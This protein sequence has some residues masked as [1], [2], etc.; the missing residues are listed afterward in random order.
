MGS[1]QA[2]E[3]PQLSLCPL[4]PLQR[5]ETVLILS[6]GSAC[7]CCCHVSGELSV[8][9]HVLIL[10]LI[11]EILLHTLNVHFKKVHTQN[12]LIGIF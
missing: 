4:D 6:L 7:L 8:D 5:R 1:S 3:A 2:Q 12:L 10:L 9:A 11:A